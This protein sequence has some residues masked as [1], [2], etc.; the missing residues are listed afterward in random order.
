[1]LQKEVNELRRRFHP[2][3]SAIQNI[4]GCYVNAQKEIIAYI[5]ESLGLMT[6]DEV[7]LY[8]T[9]LK[10]ALS[11]RLGK[12]LMDIVFSTRQVMDS[13]EHR[14]LMAL[15]ASELK[16]SAVRNAFYQKIIESLDMGD[17][18]YLILLAYDAYDVPYRGKDGM[19][20][21]DNSD[22]LYQY[23]I[24]SICPVK[25]GKLALGYFA[26]DNEFHNCLANQI[27][28][29]PELGFLFPAFDD[30]TANIYNALL[31]TRKPE[32]IHHEFIAGIFHVEPPLSAAEQ[33]EAFQA[34]LSDA[35]LA[36]MELVRSIH[37]RL[38]SQIDAHRESKEEEPLAVSADDIAAI[39]SDCGVDAD[40]ISKFKQIFAERFGAG[41]VLAPENIIDSSRFDL[42]IGSTTVSM[43]PACSYLMEARVI[44]GKKYIMVPADGEAEVN[45]FAVRIE[46]P[47]SM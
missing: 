3:K 44:E 21:D 9:L 25:D 4:Y 35:A 32:E 19:R 8:L 43:D 20:Q 22:L 30:R 33:R 12:N 6:A 11:G 47:E 28:S 41:C 46:A 10:K 2:E 7:G 45:G 26:G 38:K 18:N 31:Y 42:K 15:R 40:G 17:S 36:S 16:D 24:C 34:V 27:V 5:D 14:A 39:L 23:I 13:E 1:M 29:A 37:E